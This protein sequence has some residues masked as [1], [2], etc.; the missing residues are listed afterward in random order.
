LFFFIYTRPNPDTIPKVDLAS[1]KVLAVVKYGN[2]VYDMSVD[3]VTCSKRTLEMHYT[4]TMT[5]ENIGSTLAQSL[6]IVTDAN[7]EKVRFF[8]NGAETCILIP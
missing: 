3:T 6:L 7:F 4:C 2:D 1:K 5:D 8:E